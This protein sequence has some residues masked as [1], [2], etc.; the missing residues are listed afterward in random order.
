MRIEYELTAEDW[1]DFGESSTLNG[2]AARRG[3]TGAVR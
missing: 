3:V 2:I 1:A